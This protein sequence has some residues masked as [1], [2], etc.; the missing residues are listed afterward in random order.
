MAVSTGQQTLTTTRALIFQGDADGS[1][2][3]IENTHATVTCYV[4]N[5]SVTSANGKRILAGGAFGIDLDPS[6]AI[7]GVTASGTCT[8][9]WIANKS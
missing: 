4:G 8:I 9:D 7:Y 3:A 5:A 6:E 2:V 1:S